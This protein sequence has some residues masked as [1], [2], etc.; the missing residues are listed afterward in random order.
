[1][2]T[3]TSSCA[4]EDDGPGQGAGAGRRDGDD[5]SGEEG[6]EDSLHRIFGSLGGDGAGSDG[7]L[8]LRHGVVSGELG[9]VYAGWIRAADSDTGAGKADGHPGAEGDGEDGVERGPAEESSGA[10]V[11]VSAGGVSRRGDPGVALDA[12]ASDYGGV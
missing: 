9:A 5:G 11:L 8:Q 6:R 10:E 1:M 2:L 3:F 7:P 4:H 12:G